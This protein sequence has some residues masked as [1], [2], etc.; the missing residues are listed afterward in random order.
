MESFLGEKTKLIFDRHQDSLD[1]ISIIIP[2]KR[3]S[4]YI[5]NEFL[6]CFDK[7]FF[8]P[9]ILT[10]NEWI[11]QHTE[12]E[13]ISQ[14]EQLFILFQAHL[15]IEQSNADD[16]NQFLKWGKTILTDFDEIDRYLIEPRLIFRDLRNIKEIEN[17]S[18]DSEEPLSKSQQKF[19]GLWD[20]LPIYYEEFNALLEEQN[21]TYQGKAYADFLE[22]LPHNTQLKKHYYFLGFNALSTTEKRIMHWLY[23]EKKAD[24]FFDHDSFYL[25]NPEHEAG[26]FY[27]KLCK[28]WLWKVE[29]PA[30]FDNLPKHIQSIETSS[31]VSQAKIAGSV[32]N[33]LVEDGADM[34]KT[35]VVLADETLLIPLLR[36][37]PDSI[38]KANITM[39][40]PIRFSHLQSLVDLV[41][42]I[43]FHF[44]KFRSDKI[45]HKSLL[46]IVNH[47]FLR[48]FLNQD[49][50]VHDFEQTIIEHNRIFIEVRDIVKTFPSLQKMI[51][52]FTEWKNPSR[53]G[54]ACFNAIIEQLY[55]LFRQDE[56]SH[57]LDLEI[58]FHFS[59]A[60]KK[61]ERITD[62]YPYDYDL[63]SF[64]RL[65]YQFWQSESLSFLGNPIDGLQ[66]MG[67]LESRNLDFENLLILGLN[68]GNLPKTN[69]PNSLIP[70]D[71]KLNHQL[72]VEED[73]QAI[74]AHHFYRLL[75]RSKRLFFTYN[76]NT[77]ALNSGEKSRYLIQLEKEIDFEKVH[78]FEN[79]TFMADDRA[80]N[81]SNSRYHLEESAALKMDSR[82]A[83][84]FSPSALNKLISCPLDFYYRY[85]LDLKE[86]QEV[87]EKV[88]SST[89][90]TNIHDVLEDILKENFLEKDL[91][92]S[93]LPLK[94]AKRTAEKLLREKY[95]Q[96]FSAS[97]IKYGQNKLKFDVSVRFIQDF[98]DKQMEEIKY[99]PDPIYLVNLEETL[100]AEYEW[101]IQGQK[102]KIVL[103]GKVDRIDRINNHYRIIDYKSGKCDSSKV[104][105]GAKILDDDRMHDFMHHKDK[106]YARQ[107]L[108]YG[109]M[110]R[111][112]YPDIKHFTVGIISMVNI[113]SWIQNV[114]KT[115]GQAP[116][117]DD[118]LL[119]KFEE[120]LQ[121]KIEEI[122]SKD[123]L[124]EHNP[125]SLYCDYCQR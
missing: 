93:I 44:V 62:K 43:Q 20:Q 9:E 23:R 78:Q 92:L 98:L 36:S 122:Y 100:R 83:G 21:M 106:G 28:E 81:I 35:A 5:R 102:R 12:K 89:F 41:F 70:R 105:L 58:L 29:A 34:S 19:L 42:E 66:L 72:P 117:I 99:N 88:E 64:K 118:E 39:G 91:P 112:T 96:D 24:I 10:I 32:L 57:Q 79:F 84:G 33:D 68:E 95:L 8:S 74:F 4:V 125:K 120:E 121:L 115:K 40:Y 97:D 73:R 15:K 3:A 16:F 25:D 111:Q 13:I 6:K 55:G 45:Y 114:H 31:Q 22:N 47:P 26:Y 108:M 90:G 17:W 46:K 56:K 30:Y 38:E 124:F 49:S 52:M 87:E 101:E 80:A 77:D 94:T 113:S 119:D 18:F 54:F 107:L 61:I 2:S 51:S 86:M 123:F 37:L 11:D 82:L 67:I 59:K 109:L 103:E 76:S 53:E 75:L 116:F 65:F 110:F 7:P 71:L 63:K 1:E 27:H 48:P 50:S 60:Y 104:A 69:F 85:I 14:T